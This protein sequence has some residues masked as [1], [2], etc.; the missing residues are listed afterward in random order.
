MSIVKPNLTNNLEV[1][2]QINKV[3]KLNLESKNTNTTSNDN[4]RKLN[5]L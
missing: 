4:T 1:D 3:K 5:S 2:K